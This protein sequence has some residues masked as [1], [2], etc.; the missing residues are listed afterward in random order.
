MRRFIGTICIFGCALGVVAFWAEP[1]AQATT[2]GLKP[3][4]AGAVDTTLTVD[5]STIACVDTTENGEDEVLIIYFGRVSDGTTFTG[6]LPGDGRGDSREGHWNFNDGEGDHNRERK[7]IHLLTRDI[8]AG[9]SFTVEFLFVERDGGSYK[10]ALQVASI[11]AAALAGGD[12]VTVGQI[13]KAVSVLSEEE[14]VAELLDDSDDF[15]GSFVLTGKA[16]YKGTFS[17]LSWKAGER[18]EKRGLGKIR[19]Q[20]MV[21]KGDGS[22]YKVWLLANEG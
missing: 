14:H 1:G 18:C 15:L 19:D 6:A 5:I 8:P 20:E 10:A 11:A 3:T 16:G 17:A 21:L 2:S 13:Q 9:R 7:N 4:S 12:T 22:E